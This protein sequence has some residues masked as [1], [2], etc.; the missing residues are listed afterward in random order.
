MSKMA[1]LSTMIDDLITCGETLT[2]TG[3]A[4][5]AFYTD[6]SADTPPDPPPKRAKPEKKK[7]PPAEAPAP[8]EY[9]KE[10]VRGILA[11]KADESD[12]RFKKE[13]RELV[14]KYAKGGTLTQ[15]DAKDYATL[16]A[17][18]EGLTDA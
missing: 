6:T 3:L 5:K 7:E 8:K 1:E 18:V 14:K 15:I 2:K 10:E 17:E 13:V 16:I 12:G 4:L 9:T 11:K